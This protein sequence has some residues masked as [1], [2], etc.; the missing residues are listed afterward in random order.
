MEH[1]R[2]SYLL[3]A[4]GAV[5]AAGLSAVFLGILPALGGEMR[6]MYPEMA[7]WYWPAL[8]CLWVIFALYMT[9]MAFYF[10]IC[11]RIGKDRS[12]CREN[13]RALFRISQ[14]L[15]CAAGLWLL[16]AGAWLMPNGLMGPMWLYLILMALASGAMGCLAYALSRLIGRAVALQEENSLTI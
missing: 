10:A 5:A 7:G 4:A 1:K 9:A 11:R 14:A 15:F 12:F 3:L 2:L 16:G 8:I 13:E 6:E